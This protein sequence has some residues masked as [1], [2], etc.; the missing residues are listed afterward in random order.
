MATSNLGKWD[1]WYG[2]V[3]EP[4]PYALTPTYAMGADWLDSC[5]LVEDWA[6]P[7]TDAQLVERVRA[8]VAPKGA[9]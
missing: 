8:I 4:E 2:M 9:Q 1:D 3:S 6:E 5:E 7:H